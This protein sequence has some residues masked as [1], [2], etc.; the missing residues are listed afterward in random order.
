LLSLW[1]PFFCSLQC[2]LSSHLSALI[3]VAFPL[4]TFPTCACTCFPSRFNSDQPLNLQPAACP[5][6]CS[7]LI[8]IALTEEDIF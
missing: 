2:V 8:T 5:P 6:A 1:F 3:S 7:P 4:D